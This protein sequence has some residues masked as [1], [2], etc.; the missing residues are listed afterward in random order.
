LGGR[1]SGVKISPDSKLAL[2]E[3]SYWGTGSRDRARE[4]VKVFDLDNGRQVQGFRGVSLGALEFLPNSKQVLGKASDGILTIWDVR[5]GEVVRTLEKGRGDIDNV[6][7]SPDGRYALCSGYWSGDLQC[8]DVAKG[9]VLW[10]RDT[11]GGHVIWFTF[12]PDGQLAFLQGNQAALSVW[13]VLQG[14]PVPS[15]D[16]RPRWGTRG[17]FSPDGKLFVADRVLWSIDD[18]KKDR[19][20]LAEVPTGKE[21][22]EF[23][24]RAGGA[25]G[26][27]GARALAFLADGTRVVS[28]D[29]DY[30][31][32]LCDVQSG[33]V[34]WSA[35][36]R[37]DRNWAESVPAFSWDGQLALTVAIKHILPKEMALRLRY[38]DIDK[39]QVAREVSSDT[40]P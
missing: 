7:V 2:V 37:N 24:V 6:G 17:A 39:G 10:A 27:G 18:Q 38:W 29:D 32:R 8:W 36:S 30:M 22:R 16:R 25:A 13:H 28:A 15:F 23:A 14:K 4:P 3:F 40:V 19:L 26:P 33:R 11:G 1:V 9:K 31:I 12:Q 21:V 34:L 5:S 35:D 20:V